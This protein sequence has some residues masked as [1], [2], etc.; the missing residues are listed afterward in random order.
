MIMSKRYTALRSKVGKKFIYAKADEW[1]S[2]VSVYSPV[3]LK[4]VI[5]SFYFNNWVSFVHACH[6]LVKPSISSNDINTAH[7]HLVQFCEECNTLYTTTILSCNMHLHPHLHVREPILD[8]EPVCGYWLFGPERYNGLLKNIST[9]GK[10]SHEVTFM[11]CFLKYIY[12][13]DFTKTKPLPPT[14]FL[15]LI[16]NP[17]SISDINYTHLL[18]Y[19]KFGY[20]T[21]NI[22]H[23]HN[24][25]SPLFSDDQITKLKSIDVLG[26]VSY[27]NNGTTGHESYLQ[28]LF[29]GNRS[30]DKD[31]VEICGSP[32]SP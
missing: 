14:P 22:V 10:S 9:N 13:D 11:G 5:P 29:L 6:Y 2:W 16:S 15:L 17:S 19:S 1:K 31:G 26:Q 20:L 4:S 30:R 32:L 23:Y 3:T 12:K 28:S 25:A 21:L 24:S 8:F 7:R 27:G 18:A